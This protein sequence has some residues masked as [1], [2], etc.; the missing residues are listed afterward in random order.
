MLTRQV[1]HARRVAGDN[2]RASRAEKLRFATEKAE[3]YGSDA[4]NAVSTTVSNIGSEFVNK[5]FRDDKGR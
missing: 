3:R 2:P 5:I 4:A 1:D